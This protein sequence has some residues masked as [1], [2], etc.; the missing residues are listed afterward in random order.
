[1][2]TGSISEP[3]HAEFPP[4]VLKIKISRQEVQ[5]LILNKLL[6][7]PAA[8]WSLRERDTLGTGRH[9]SKALRSDRFV[10]AISSGQD[11]VFIVSIGYTTE[12]FFAEYLHTQTSSFIL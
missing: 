8:K 3:R 7:G 9:S 11:E 6:T 2:N 10:K 4:A 12:K 5:H 1:M